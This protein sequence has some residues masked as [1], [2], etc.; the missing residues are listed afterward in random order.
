MKMENFY[1]EIARLVPRKLRYFILIDSWAK[2]TASPK[3]KES[4][5]TTVYMTEVLDYFYKQD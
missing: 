2:Y 3:H 4:D 1:R 5:I